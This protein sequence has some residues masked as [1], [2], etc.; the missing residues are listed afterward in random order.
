MKKWAAY[1][2]E[3]WLFDLHADSQLLALR[4]A[5]KIDASV[6]HVELIADSSSAGGGRFS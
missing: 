1:A 6:T 5:Q 3:Q 4:D 2:G